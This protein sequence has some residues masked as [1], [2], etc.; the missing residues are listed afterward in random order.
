[1]ERELGLDCI[2]SSWRSDNP[3]PHRRDLSTPHYCPGLPLGGAAR[4]AGVLG[5]RREE[6]VHDPL[7]TGDSARFLDPGA[8]CGG[9]T[10]P[11]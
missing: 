10:P 6:L 3:P 11:C 5:L 8:A 2:T 9:W 1:M 7:A 4:P